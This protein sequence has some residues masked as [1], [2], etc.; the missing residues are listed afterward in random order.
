MLK[1]GAT[2]RISKKVV[3]QATLMSILNDSVQQNIPSPF[4]MLGL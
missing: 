3:F 2:K 1:K 4:R